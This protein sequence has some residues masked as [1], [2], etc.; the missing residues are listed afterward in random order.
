MVSNFAHL[1]KAASG[2]KRGHA[3][4]PGSERKHGGRAGGEAW[5]QRQGAARRRT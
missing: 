2:H 5:Q 1:K 4:Q 3:A